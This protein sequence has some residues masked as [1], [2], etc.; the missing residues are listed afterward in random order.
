MYKYPEE[1]FNTLSELIVHESQEA[2][3]YSD[4]RALDSFRAGRYT[5]ETKNIPLLSKLRN[6]ISGGVSPFHTEVY[7]I[8]LTTLMDIVW[9]T[10]DR[11]PV[12]D[13]KYGY[14]YEVGANGSFGLKIVDGRNL[15][16]N[17][18]GT[19][20]NMKINEVKKYFKDQIIAKVKSL[21]ASELSKY[22]YNEVNQQLENISEQLE[23]KI[24]EKMLSYGIQIINF[25]VST[26]AIKTEDLEKLKNLD[27][28][29]VAKKY[30]A[31]IR[32]YDTIMDADAAAIARERQG[33]TWQQEQQFGIGKNF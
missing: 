15:L 7:F 27:N 21:L 8:N 16:I 30:Q 2:V 5:L 26:I 20:S 25:F 22:S 31:E 3:F 29:M 4:G 18:V 17:L 6:L 23:K 14:N 10:P 1:D 32:H 13:P 24:Q 9:G 33:F 28:E 19:A 11:I 12:R